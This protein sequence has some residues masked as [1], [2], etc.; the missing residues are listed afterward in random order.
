V[1]F[2]QQKMLH[3]LTEQA[4]KRSQPLIISNLNH[5]KLDVLNQGLAG[6]DK[7]EQV[8]MQAL[9]MRVWP[10]GTAIDLLVIKAVAVEDGVVSE[11][12][13]K[14]VGTPPSV[15]AA[16]SDSDMPEFVS[17]LFHVCNWRIRKSIS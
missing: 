8:C 5:E 12:Y 1:F 7:L 14:S 13:G 9:C 11:L 3:N 10:G 6:M 4:L 16:V 17:L 2:K 15:V